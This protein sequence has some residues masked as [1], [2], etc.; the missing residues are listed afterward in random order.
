MLGLRWSDIDPDARTLTV[1]LA[2]QRLPATETEPS[3]LA[4]VQAKTS[5]SRRSVSFP[6]VVLLN[7]ILPKLVPMPV[8]GLVHRYPE[9]EKIATAIAA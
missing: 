3:R 8:P 5:R 6:A 2:L 9:L 1:A 4:L 7:G